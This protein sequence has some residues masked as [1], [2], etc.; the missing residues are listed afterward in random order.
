[1]GDLAPKSGL[2]SR[3]LHLKQA[4]DLIVQ[5]D[6]SVRYNP[7]PNNPLDFSRSTELSALNSLLDGMTR[8]ITTIG[9]A[10]D[11]IAA[12][13]KL[14][15]LAL[16]LVSQ[17]QKTTDTNVRAKLA[18]QFN[19]LLPQIDQLAADANFNGVNLLE[20]SDLRIVTNQNGCSGVVVT[21]FNA[22]VSGDLAIN[23]PKNTWAT[24]SEIQATADNLN[25]A[26]VYLRSRAQSLSDILSTIQIREHFIKTMINTLRSGA[27]C[28]TPA[29]S[30][31]ESAN[32]LALKTR[33]Q[34]SNVSRWLA[35]QADQNV[36]RLLWQ[37]D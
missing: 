32:L 6:T 34:S 3:P 30:N 15:Q 25:L 20:G 21:A 19:A 7:L 36:V 9:A 8:G 12:I 27:D 1:M 35:T 29:D 13:A 28:R 10:N 33:Q 17:A 24:N 16:A 37:A 4:S 23:K 2:R 18:D 14:V 31:K 5:S 26:L 11:G 22:T